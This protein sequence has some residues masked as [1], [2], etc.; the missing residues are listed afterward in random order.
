M[1]VIKSIKLSGFV[2][3]LYV[4]DSAFT[5]VKK[6]VQ[7]TG[8]GVPLV[9]R[10]YMIGVPF[11]SN[12]VYKRLRGWAVGRNLVPRAPWDEVAWGG[13]SPSKTLLSTQRGTDRF[14]VQLIKMFFYIHC[15]ADI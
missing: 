10:R 8:K 11:L 9:N 4:K 7:T 12:M 6:G 3:Y 5:A 15:S 1:A 14:Y 2:I 13:A